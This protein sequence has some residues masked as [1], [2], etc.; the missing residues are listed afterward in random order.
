MI[1]LNR[2][3]RLLHIA[4]FNVRQ[5]RSVDFS[6]RYVITDQDKSDDEEDEYDAFDYDNLLDGFEPEQS[7]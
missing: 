7:K 6:Q 4:T 2:I 3:S 1:E 5:R